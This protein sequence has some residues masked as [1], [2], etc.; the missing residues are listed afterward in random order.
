MYILRCLLIFACFIYSVCSEN[1]V[2]TN[3]SKPEK[4]IITQVQFK[5]VSTDV[6]LV[7][8]YSGREQDV[9]KVVPANTIDNDVPNTL[10]NSVIKGNVSINGT[11][12]KSETI[13]PVKEKTNVLSDTLPVPPVEHHGKIVPKKGVNLSE[14]PPILPPNISVSVGPLVDKSNS[15]AKV[16]VTD[17]PKKPLFTEPEDDTNLNIT[18]NK[19]HENIL[20]IDQID[21]VMANKKSNRSDYVVLIVAVILS[22]P[23]IAFLMSIIYKRSQDWWQHRYYKR[24]DFLIEGMYHN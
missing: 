12:E 19:E 18:D 9:V 23:L 15:S 7:K 6:P 16:N 17:V 24:M 21:P 10:I 11:I 4:V 3:T 22:V 5:N 8:K 13:K 2:V 20:T 1:E 14:A